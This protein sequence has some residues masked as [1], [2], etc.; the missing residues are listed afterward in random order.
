MVAIVSGDGLLLSLVM[1]SF[2]TGAA[3]ASHSSRLE[4]EEC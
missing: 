1:I 2:L 4:R 3:L